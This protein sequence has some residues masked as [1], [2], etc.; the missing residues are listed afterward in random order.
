MKYRIITNGHRFKV[1]GKLPWYESLPFGEW[2][3]CSWECETKEEAQHLIDI[4]AKV[5]GISKL[6]WR[7]V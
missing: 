4:K 2:E 1:Q 7:E 6:E 5:D 3:D